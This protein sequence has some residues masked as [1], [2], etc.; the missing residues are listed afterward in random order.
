MKKTPAKLTSEDAV[1]KRSSLRLF[2]TPETHSLSRIL[3]TVGDILDTNKSVGKIEALANSIQASMQR[4]DQV[5]AEP[6][7]ADYLAMFRLVEYML[8]TNGDVFQTIDVPGQ[9]LVKPV[10][11]SC[12]DKKAEETWQALWHD[13]LDIDELFD[14]FFYEVEQN[15][16]CFPLEIWSKDKKDIKGIAFL[17]PTSMWV[18]RHFTNHAMMAPPNFDT[19]KLADMIHP[20]AYS[21]FV[22]DLNV[23]TSVWHRQPIADDA[24]T[25]IYGRK[26]AYQRYALPPTVR[27]AGNIM[28]RQMLDELRRGTMEGFINQLI[29]ATVGSEKLTPQMNAQLVTKTN[30]QLS[31]QSKERTGLLVGHWSLKMDVLTPKA[32]DQMM[33]DEAYMGLTQSIFRGLGFSL[34]LASGEVPGKRGS[35]AQIDMDIQF[36]IERWKYKRLRI[37]KWYHKFSQ[38]WAGRNDPTLLKHLPTFTVEPIGVE[39]TLA[40]KDKLLPMA[41]GGHLSER[42]FL[43]H[44]GVSTYDEELKNKKDEEKNRELFLPPPSFN[45]MTVNPDGSERQFPSP[46]GGRPNQIKAQLFQDDFRESID[47]QFG[48]LL[49]GRGSIKAFTHWLESQMTLRLTA[50]FQDGY[51]QWGGLG[52]LSNRVLAEAPQGIPYHVEH[53]RTFAKD[54][55]NSKSP[56]DL[57]PRALLY[58]GAAHI[59]YM[60]GAQQAMKTHGAKSW[61]RI[62]HPE[63]SHAGPCAECVADAAT[64]HDISEPFWEPHPSGVCSV[65]SLNFYFGDRMPEVIPIPDFGMPTQHLT[66]R[67]PVQ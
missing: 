43:S 19:Q 11:I 18:G 21:S 66:R 48:R 16:N 42:T 54:L 24:M 39:Q 25:P 20:L 2:D 57:R 33:G 63:L 13:V 3:A 12:D 35:G 17:E 29:Y 22:T 23:Q 5:E 31:A 52:E 30:N 60:I 26:L 7:P 32:I 36:A 55:S 10:H 4:F 51:L 8:R 64:I 46:V 41:Q 40:I 28:H 9:I 44:S 34:F 1:L 53:L 49:E 14:E 6:P 65:Q 58:A 45:Q 61:Q 56:I 50:A 37:L 67:H 59:A 62:L 38:K 27:E 15:S 47:A